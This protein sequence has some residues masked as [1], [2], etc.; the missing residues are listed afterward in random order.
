MELSHSAG[1]APRAPR[2]QSAR[3][4]LAPAPSEQRDDAQQPQHSDGT[5]SVGKGGEPLPPFVLHT[6]TRSDTIDGLAFKYRVTKSEIKLLNDLPSDNIHTCSVLKIPQGPRAPLPSAREA[7]GDTKAAVLRRFRVTH[8]LDESEAR[9][10]LEEASYDEKLAEEALKADLAFERQNAAAVN[11]AVSNAT[12][13]LPS[14]SSRGGAMPASP[15]RAAPLM[16]GGGLIG[17]LL[18]S[19][20]AAS[21]SAS[22]EGNTVESSSLLSRNHGRG[23][24]GAGLGSG[25]AAGS[26]VT[27]GMG[28]I[29]RHRKKDA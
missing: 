20:R 25:V 27:T 10:Y 6:V 7:Q 11:A 17:A 28:T 29:L 21:S 2:T 8:G 14:G 19:S 3:D 1:G 24:G 18:G 13:N 4:Y 22:E 16:S 23:G 15:A 26:S 9:Y 12:I 5:A